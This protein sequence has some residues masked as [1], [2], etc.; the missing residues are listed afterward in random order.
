MSSPPYTALVAGGGEA[1]LIGGVPDDGGAIV[2]AGDDGEPVDS[3]GR[4]T[5]VESLEDLNE[6]IFNRGKMYS[7]LNEAELIADL[8]A[9]KQFSEQFANCQSKIEREA[10]VSKKMHIAT[11]KMENTINNQKT[12]AAYHFRWL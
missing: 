8:T 4:Y 6:M 10:M 11:N 5:R 2:A 9:L 12:F 7:F 3:P 1:P